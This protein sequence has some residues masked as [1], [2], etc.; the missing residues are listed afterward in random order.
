MLNWIFG[1]V[2]SSFSFFIISFIAVVYVGRY[3]TPMVE[4]LAVKYFCK[5]APL[6]MFDSVLSTPLDTSIHIA[7]KLLLGKSD[8]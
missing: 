4:V 8:T 5:K 3:Q 2:F 7:L 6:Y 1:F